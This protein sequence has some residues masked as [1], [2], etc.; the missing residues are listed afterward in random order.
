[1]STEAGQRDVT[2]LA[3]RVRKGS[4]EPR[5]AVPPAA[6]K[7]Q[8]NTFSPEPPAGTSPADTVILASETRFRLLTS[9]TVR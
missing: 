8:G 1:M 6:G 4:R 9:R 7:R 3:L 5:N 2:F